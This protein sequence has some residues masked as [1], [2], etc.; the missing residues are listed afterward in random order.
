MCVDDGRVFL[1]GQV[2]P[3]VGDARG[4]SSTACAGS[5]PSTRSRRGRCTRT[6]R[7]TGAGASTTTTPTRCSAASVPRRRARS[8]A[9]DR[10][11][12]QGPRRQQRVLLAGRHRRRPPRRTPTSRS[13][14][15]TRATTAPTKV[16]TPEATADTA[17]NRLLASL[18]ARRHRPGANVYAELGSTWWNVMRDPTQAAHVL[19][20]LLARVSGADRVLLG[21]RLDLVRLAAG[22]DPGVPHVRDLATQFQE[23]FGY[24]ALTDDDE[25]EDVR[26]ER[27]ASCT[28]SSP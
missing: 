16:R 20:K 5:R 26:A 1:H 9:E 3:N 19:G 11:R 27:R 15:T 13:S 2:N 6:C 14:C 24:P 4:R 18:D 8:R 12:A 22:P 25:A 21:H 28:A 17:S 10:V 23:Q 7:T